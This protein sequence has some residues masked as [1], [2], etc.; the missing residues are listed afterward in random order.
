MGYKFKIK[1]YTAEKHAEKFEK[2]MKIINNQYQYKPLVLT[3]TALQQ[4]GHLTKTEADVQNRQVIF[5]KKKQKI[6]IEGDRRKYG[7]Y[8]V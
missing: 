4:I 3:E 2:I 7:Y 8:W 1:N 5:E 6:Y